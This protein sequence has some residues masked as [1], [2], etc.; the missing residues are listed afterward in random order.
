[1]EERK[2][3]DCF[4]NKLKMKDTKIELCFKT[5]KNVKFKQT[6]R[7]IL[8]NKLKT[9]DRE[10]DKRKREREEWFKIILKVK[11][12]RVRQRPEYLRIT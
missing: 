9:K 2:R 6:Q 7:I 12:D 3:E 4:Y 11:M 10:S 1:M 8:K 5:N